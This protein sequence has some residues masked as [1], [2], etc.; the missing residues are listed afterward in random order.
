MLKDEFKKEEQLRR[1]LDEYK[2]DIPVKLAHHR[3]RNRWE[4][5]LAYLASPAKDPLTD[6]ISSA[7][8]LIKFTFM[9]V[10]G[11]VCIAIFQALLL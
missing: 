1:Q 11:A 2:V 10:A 4:H 9:P 3:K 7:G 8:G 6:G 5:F